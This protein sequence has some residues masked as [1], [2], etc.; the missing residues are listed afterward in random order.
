MQENFDSPKTPETFNNIGTFRHSNSSL[1][2]YKFDFFHQGVNRETYT[3][4]RGLDLA[5]KIPSL[6]SSSDSLK[7]PKNANNLDSSQFSN[8]F[9]LGIARLDFIGQGLKSQSNNRNMQRSNFLK[10]K[11]FCSL[12][13]NFDNPNLPVSPR[14]SKFAV[15]FDFFPFSNS[16]LNVGTS[17]GCLTEVCIENIALD[18]LGFLENSITLSFES[19]C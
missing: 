14:N 7:V 1:A 18:L 13:E 10:N 16:L 3:V 9:F 4:E 6:D 19:E 15:D 11:S 17:L 2:F 8:S 12:V 5:K